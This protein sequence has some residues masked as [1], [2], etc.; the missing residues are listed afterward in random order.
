VIF[1]IGSIIAVQLLFTY[2]PIMNE[3]FHSAPMSGGSWLRIAA[4][5]AIAFGAVELEKWIRFR[6]RTISTRRD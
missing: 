4:V 6:R 1:G 3:L 5:G 2:V